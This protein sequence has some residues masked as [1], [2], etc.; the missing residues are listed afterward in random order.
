MK[1]SPMP[2]LLSFL[3]SLAAHNQKEWMD[4]HRSTYQALRKEFIAL[5]DEVLSELQAVDP[6]LHG[7]EAKSL[8]YRI[9]RDVRFS[10]DKAPYNPWFSAMLAEGGRHSEQAGYYLRIQAGNQTVVGGG[11]Y[12]PTPE[13]LRKMRQ[14]IDYNAAELREI[15]QQS[16]FRDTFGSIQGEM[17]SRAPKGYASDHPNL[18]LLK[19]KDYIA[20][21]TFT[22]EEVKAPGFVDELKRSLKSLQPFIDFLNVAIS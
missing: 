21:R 7:L 3:E 17:L 18:E 22:D 8:I 10:K 5:V 2:A 16:S 9:N 4:E 20:L 14:E 1:H 12:C 19:L 13:Q 11:L 15:V 6:G